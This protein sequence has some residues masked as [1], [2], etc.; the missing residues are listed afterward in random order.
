MCESQVS[1]CAVVSRGS[2]GKGHLVELEGWR[3]KTFKLKRQADAW[4]KKT[5]VAVREGTHVADS[6]SITVR[7]A[8]EL[9][10]KTCEA[11]RLERTTI[12]QYRQHLRLHIVGDGAC[13]RSRR[14]A[15]SSA[16]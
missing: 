10:I 14:K 4:E 8:G 9:W 5:G 12:E 3:F 2:E 15:S 7:E 11:E 6:A 13:R 1:K 16:I